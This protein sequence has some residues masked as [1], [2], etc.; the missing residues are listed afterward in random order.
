MAS[1]E[2]LKQQMLSNNL[3]MGGA[4][5]NYKSPIRQ[6]FFGLTPEQQEQ[7]DY[8][9][10]KINNRMQEMAM[11][12]SN[13]P[14][15]LARDFG[16]EL[17]EGFFNPLQKKFL[18][19]K[20]DKQAQENVDLQR[21]LDQKLAS[22]PDASAQD[23]LLEVGNF[24]IKRG[25]SA[26][27]LKILQSAGANNVEKT[28]LI[29]NLEAAGISPT[30]PEGKAIIMES[31]KGKGTNIS[32][33]DKNDKRFDAKTVLDLNAGEWLKRSTGEAIE[34]S[35][36]LTPQYQA[37]EALT[38]QLGTEG[39]G[40]AA[41]AKF[42]ISKLAEY[43]GLG[44]DETAPLKE[45]FIAVTGKLVNDILKS[46]KGIQ[47]DADEKRVAKTISALGDTEAGARFKLKYA[48]ALNS[49]IQQRNEFILEY[50]KENE[51]VTSRDVQS[52]W[53]KHSKSNPVN[54]DLYVP[55]DKNGKKQM[56]I[57]FK[58]YKENIRNSEGG[59]QFTDEQI[60]NS[61]KKDKKLRK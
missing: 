6:S 26:D 18:P 7:V 47:T 51:G 9:Q 58:Q 43:F 14:N 25:R 53:Q 46:A 42:Q 28:S 56:P 11:T 59:D 38:N 5:G 30:S 35:E 27:G 13:T 40:N 3:N 21:E 12:G 1:R 23:K 29:K 10:A 49:D 45:S 4:L 16:F 44:F 41:Q 48:Q 36:S 19:S 50:I 15:S 20:A 33:G 34:D 24:L 39:F 61:W 57:F 2:A 52:A 32:I 8:E 54:S 37:A 60:V 31:A 55:R 17:G 22:M